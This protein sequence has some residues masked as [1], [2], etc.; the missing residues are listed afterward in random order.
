MRREPQAESVALVVELDDG[1]PSALTETAEEAG[2]GVEREL[3][4][5][6]W[7]VTV[8]ETAIDDLCALDGVVRIETAATLEHG[9]DETIGGGADEDPATEDEGAGTG[10]R[11]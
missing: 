1:D 6:C 3:P 7:L 9:V 8:P 5:D 11:R 2:G 10:E 4:F